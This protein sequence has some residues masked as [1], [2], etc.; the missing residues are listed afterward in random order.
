MQA[1]NI[2]E[3]NVRDLDALLRERD[4]QAA[5]L[6]TEN[7]NIRGRL[8]MM[9]IQAG[10]MVR[11]IN[12]MREE[13]ASLRRRLDAAQGK[14]PNDPRRSDSAP[15]KLPSE[16]R[17]ES[18]DKETSGSMELEDEGKGKRRAE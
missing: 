18:A 12:K 5:N 17:V 11:E 7:H 10:M 6:R 4:T 9:N 8:G 2:R 15:P 16:T 13:N 14:N 3:M 1:W